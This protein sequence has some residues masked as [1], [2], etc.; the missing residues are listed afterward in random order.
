VTRLNTFARVIRHFGEFGAS[1]H[2]L[3]LTQFILL[4]VFSQQQ[5]QSQ[6]KNRKS[7]LKWF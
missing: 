4:W 6:L 1:G 5:A 3:G 2:C 7:E